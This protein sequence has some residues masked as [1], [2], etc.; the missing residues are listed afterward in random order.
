MESLKIIPVFAEQFA[1]SSLKNVTRRRSGQSIGPNQLLWDLGLDVGDIYNDE[2]VKERIKL[3]EEKFHLVMILENFE[4]CM[5]GLGEYVY[6][7]LCTTYCSSEIAFYKFRSKFI[8]YERNGVD[9]PQCGGL[10]SHLKAGRCKTKTHSGISDPDE[11]PALLGGRG[12]HQLETQC[13]DS[14]CGNVLTI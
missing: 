4:V 6:T 12:Y 13:P 3:M 5:T 1:S 11:T 2:A 9:I 7:I 14:E 8:C 10:K